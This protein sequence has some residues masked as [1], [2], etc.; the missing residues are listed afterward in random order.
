MPPSDSASVKTLTDSA[1]RR[2]GAIGLVGGNSVGG[3]D[4]MRR[5]WSRHGPIPQI[6]TFSSSE[7]NGGLHLS[8]D[9]VLVGC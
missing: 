2:Y 8:T 6:S 5:P 3:G 4:R 7:L 9:C 1:G